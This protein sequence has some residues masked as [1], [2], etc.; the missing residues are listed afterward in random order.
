MDVRPTVATVDL[1]AIC[2][3]M[4][5]ARDLA[6]GA[7]VCAI[8]KAHAYGHGLVQ[9]GRALADA[10]A[11]WLAVALVEEGTTLRDAGVKR[12][13]L[14]LGAALDGGFDVLIEY[15]LTPA[16][17]R[18][19]HLDA[20]AAAAGD[21]DVRFH[22]KIDT[23]MA[24]L[25][26]GTD[27]IDAFCDALATKSNL[28]LDGVLTHFANAD[29]ADLEFGTHQL[30]L[31]DRGCE[32]LAARGITPRWV[33]IS[34]SAAV[35]SFPEAHRKLLRPGLMLYGLDPRVQR[36]PA[37]LEPAMRWT[38]RPIHIK[39]VPAGTRVSYGG[40]W[41]S[42][43]ETRLMTLPVGYA[44]GYPRAMTGKAEVVVRGVRVPVIGS[45]CMDLCMADVT[46]VPGVTLE[47]EVVLI[48]KQ[49]HAEVTAYDLAQWAGTIP[50]EITCGVSN[51][52]PR[53]YVGTV[54]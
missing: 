36:E 33:H 3:N 47:D 16:I 53:L 9:V 8:V 40:R 7:A 32:A 35:L 49:G 30:A 29:L 46:D 27:E 44:D 42:Q 43:R 2:H 1:A 4:Q 15:D 41:T 52:V 6:P 26:L 24:R 51:R 48:G 5:V 50:Y 19:E 54:G 10:G 31:F 34:N 22:L 20:L 38:T 18:T 39:T 14:V 11:E 45:I 12:P 17:F 28:K 13:I 25:G 23:G 21:R 37:G